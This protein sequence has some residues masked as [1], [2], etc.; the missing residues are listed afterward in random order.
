MSNNS[1]FLLNQGEHKVMFN[2]NMYSSNIIYS[3]IYEM[4]MT[5]TVASKPRRVSDVTIVVDHM[6][7]PKDLDTLL[8]KSE[9]L[10]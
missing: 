8:P 7:H 10:S 2:I 5:H 6:S 4:H 1:Y 9:V 3:F